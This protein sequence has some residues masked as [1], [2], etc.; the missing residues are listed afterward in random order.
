[1]ARTR[2]AILSITFLLNLFGCSTREFGLE[3][4]LK[5]TSVGDE[6][7]VKRGDAFAT[8]PQR[9]QYF[10]QKTLVYASQASQELYFYGLN[11]GELW[12]KKIN[13]RPEKRLLIENFR[14]LERD[15]VLISFNEGFLF[16]EHDSLLILYDLNDNKV[17]D[18]F[19]FKGSEAVMYPYNSSRNWDSSDFVISHTI[20]LVMNKDSIVALPVLFGCFACEE[21]FVDRKSTSLYLVHPTKSPAYASVNFPCE[22]KRDSVYP[23]HL[24]YARGAYNAKDSMFIFSFGIDN[25]IIKYNFSTGEFVKLD[26]I[27]KYLRVV[28]PTSSRFDKEGDYFYTDSKQCRYLDIVYNPIRHEYYRLV[29]L[30]DEYLKISALNYSLDILLVHDSD[31]VFKYVIALP[32]G[33]TMPFLPAKYGFYAFNSVKSDTSSNYYFSYIVLD[34]KWEELDDHSISTDFNVIEELD[35]HRSL[36]DLFDSVFS[37]VL[38]IPADDICF[39][40][41]F[42]L[43]DI[44][45]SVLSLNSSLRVV[46]VCGRRDYYKEL[47]RNVND[48]LLPRVKHSISLKIPSI[49]SLDG[50]LIWVKNIDGNLAFKLLSVTEFIDDPVLQ[51]D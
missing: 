14:F 51:W 3:A 33:Y 24:T 10:D 23:R 27:P 16:A 6:L 44:L 38:V 46:I 28:Q 21:A 11:T 37:D 42:G 9:I 31:Y 2:A 29:R 12:S 45:N 25:S 30:P 19:N 15:V 26:H 17:L 32:R 48:H 22:N 41:R 8:M 13:F 20:D 34:E 50:E 18:A 49:S 35:V 4:D 47:I 40:C 7:I 36:S 5:H 1:M 39:S 43:Q